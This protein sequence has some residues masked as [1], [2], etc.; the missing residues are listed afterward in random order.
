MSA[1]AL[2]SYSS[3]SHLFNFD[4][5]VYEVISYKKLSRKTKKKRN[6]RK[7]STKDYTAYQYLRSKYSWLWNTGF[8][9]AR[10]KYIR[11]AIL[12]T[13]YGNNYHRIANVTAT[14]IK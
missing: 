1:L 3:D 8:R 7:I 2:N 9:T 14:V 13:E 10:S 5:L 12:K 6:I 4:N 11:D